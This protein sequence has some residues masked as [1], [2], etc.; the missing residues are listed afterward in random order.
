MNGNKKT[1]TV[2]KITVLGAHTAACVMRCKQLPTPGEY[3]IGQEFGPSLDGAKGSNQA[4]AAARLGAQTA[5]ISC[6]GDDAEGKKALN[7]LQ[8]CG[9]DTHF[10]RVCPNISTG[11]GIAFIDATGTPMGV[12][13][14][15]ANQ[16]LDTLAVEAAGQA[17]SGA[18]IALLSL[19]I[20]LEAACRG[21]ELAREAGALV[22]LNPS[23]ANELA[24][25]PVLLKRFSTVIDWITPN[26]PEAKLLA[27]LAA[28]AEIA[29]E[30][31]IRLLAEKTGLSQIVITLGEQGAIVFSQG[32]VFWQR[33]PKIKAIDTSG[34]GDCFNAAFACSL[35]TG[36]SC[37]KATAY[38]VCAASLSVGRKEVWPSYPNAQEAEAALIRN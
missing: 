6:V 10:V 5:L 29:P 16:Y 34:A 4:I 3:I 11:I 12:T 36:E 13:S 21:A 38:A 30:P 18:D 17:F 33:A 20:P 28:D 14:L 27:G 25:N 32:D 24:E 22:I 8:G 37:Q 23:P 31:L 15:G 26:E 7:Y 19:E 2:P 9:V 35:G 1:K